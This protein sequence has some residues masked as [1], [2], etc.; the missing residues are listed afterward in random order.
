MPVEVQITFDDP[1]FQEAVKNPDGITPHFADAM[2]NIMA[3]FMDKASEYAPES[4]ANAPGRIDKNGKPM[5]FYER[6]RGWW[7]P[8]LTQQGLGSA[9]GVVLFRGKK[10]NPTSTKLGTSLKAVGFRGVAGYHLRET[11]EQM[12]KQWLTDVTQNA[13]EIVGELTNTASYS[14]Y[15]QGVEQI[16]LHK[17]REWRQTTPTVWESEEVQNV[18]RD[19]VFAAIDQF[20]GLS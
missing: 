18:V 8:I 19:E 3:V 2:K 9:N 17:E 4:E 16:V 7:Y 6:G 13:N 5:G 1:K 12:D 15:V 20:Y 10:K 14:G 11:S